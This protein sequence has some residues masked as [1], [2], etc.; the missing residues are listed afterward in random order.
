MILQADLQ[1]MPP[2]HFV[3]VKGQ[4]LFPGKVYFL[5]RITELRKRWE[6]LCV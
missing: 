6:L 2:R 1:T 3:I 4:I 5:I